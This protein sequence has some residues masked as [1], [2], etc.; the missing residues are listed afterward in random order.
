MSWWR[1]I[2][3]SLWYARRTHG[4]VLLAAAVG[5]AVLVGALAVGDSM[6]FTLGQSMGQRLGKTQM[7]LTVPHGFVTTDLS[8][9]LSKALDATVA[10]V[11]FS[12]GIVSDGAGK[13]RI[14]QVN[15]YGVDSRF[16]ELGD[17]GNPL[18][19]L[20]ADAVILNDAVM[21]KLQVQAGDTVVLRLD[22]PETLSRDL[23]LVSEANRT[24]ASRLTVGA[25]ARADQMG[26]FSLE[27]NQAVAANVFVPMDWLAAQ[28]GQPGMINV[29]L[30]SGTAATEAQANAAVQTCWD[31]RDVG[32]EVVTLTQ[33]T[34]YELR[35]RRV[36]F[37][38]SI[39]DILLAQADQASGVLT[40]FVNRLEANAKHTPY[41][42]VAAVKGPGLSL[43]E[44]GPDDMVVSQWLADDLGLTVGQD[45]TVAY[46][47]PGVQQRGLVEKAKTFKVRQ[48][49]PMDHPAVDANL[50]PEFPGMSNVDNCRDWDTG[51][52]VV[53]DEIRDKDEDYW[54]Q[55]RG[56]PKAFV[57]LGAGQA[58]WANQYGNLTAVR[59]AGTDAMV[60]GQVRRLLT[61]LDPAALGLYFNPVRAMSEKALAQGTDFGPL[62]LG[63]SMFLIVG[64][65]ILTGLLFAFS[66]E[67]RADQTG[68][69]LALGVPGRSVMRVY[70]LE[71]LVLSVVGSIVGV[72]VGL[73]YA[74]GLTLALNYLWQGAIASA[75]VLFFASVKSCVTGAVSGIVTAVLAMVVTL[76]GQR[77]IQARALLAGD[78][79]T[80]QKPGKDRKDRVK[81]AVAI[82]ALFGA[83]VMV[84][85]PSQDSE[86]QAGLF[87]GAGA[88]CLV[89]GLCLSDW[90][91]AR[92]LQAW[93]GQTLSTQSLALRNTTRRRSRSVAVISL[94]AVGVFV[95]V[96][97]CAN[98]R[99]PLAT[100]LSRASGTGGFAWIG[101]FSAGVLQ[102]LNTAPGQ[103]ALGLDKALLV[104]THFVPMRVHDG[105]EASCLNLNRAQS[106][107]L[108]GVDPNA[109]AS[110]KAFTF[111]KTQEVTDD[112]WLLLNL[113]LGPNK[114]PVIVDKPTADWGLNKG[115][116]SLAYRDDQ[117]Q[118][119][120]GRIVGV[121]G[122]SMLQGNLIM[123]EKNFTAR[124]KS[125]EGYRQVLIE[126]DPNQ[127]QAVGDH[128]TDRLQDLG[129]SLTGS[130]ERLA[131]L[132][133]VENTY[134]NMFLALGGLG[135]AL[136]SVGMALVVLRNCLDRRAEFAML[137]AVG[138]DR[139]HIQ[140]LAFYE[141]WGL[142]MAGLF[143]G[144]LA[145][146]IAVTPA[147]R[148]S[149]YK[150]PYTGIVLL[151]AGMAVFGAL[152]VW[153]AVRAALRGSLMESLRSE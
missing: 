108:L 79:G 137:R 26:R 21:E 93:H 6:R 151:L 103:E 115:T 46:Y 33:D 123:S 34:A 59:V 92:L 131:A 152:W 67:S 69:L 64:A 57:S 86:M 95:V 147:V 146:A 47:V 109:L 114:V 32:L 28:M 94:L 120:Y 128:L 13:K 45:V 72:G 133:Q 127:I 77:R 1:F 116:D 22:K 83:I 100:S 106:P 102:D 7:A 25:V 97:V 55:Y 18:D 65:M 36:F 141:H 136:G 148:Q 29:M 49:I 139:A 14:N 84:L 20:A 76:R 135:L 42:M 121:M 126:T 111:V 145:A 54:D 140:R 143:W 90:L 43:P 113:D 58:L 138:L 9:R 12:R 130:R 66:I 50:M 78:T 38:T 153:F 63:L 112:P 62:F 4:A 129:L 19:G 89:F 88:L 110:R 105:D 125:E 24:V 10:P 37:E 124:F 23:V 150:V 74:K 68:L 142:L 107:R 82:A 48:I 101:Q 56:S 3:K 30:V 15:I 41:S 8:V 2:I 85:V 80:L 40:Y 99:D 17:G 104:K 70:L 39:S 31:A 61:T 44:L 35:S 118:L 51:V 16:F 96:A 119:F 60:Q 75:S 81:L 149:S 132:S 53:L 27:A 73:V 5:T 117:G 134:L 122:G 98:R 52:P 11:L 144:T 87:F 91:L 71:G